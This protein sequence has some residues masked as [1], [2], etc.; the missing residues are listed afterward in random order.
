MNT[1]TETSAVCINIDE[2]INHDD[3]YLRLMRQSITASLYPE[4]AWRIL[5]SEGRKGIIGRIK[6]FMIKQLAKKNLLLVK[7]IPYDANRR[8]FGLDWPMF[9]YSMVGHRRLENIE[10][11]IR[12]VVA[13]NI[14]GDIVEC[15]VWRGGAS[16][17]AKAVLNVLDA[18]NRTLWLADSFE[19]MPVQNEADRV[20]P[21][22]D[23]CSFLAVSLDEVQENFTRFG[24]LDDKVKF[25]KGW[26]SDTL[27][28]APIK[29]IAVLRLDGD[30]YSS[31]MDTLNAL[32]NRVTNGGYIIIDDYGDFESCR[33]AVTEFCG[34]HGIAPII[35]PIDSNGVFWRKV[36]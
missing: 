32:F 14:D 30:Y 11:C 6:Y 20:D 7:K 2:I 3:P 10:K 35:I 25:I 33:R 29:R 9:G 36:E 1:N 15:G 27:P 24:L 18:D 34:N 13:E 28:V 12:S 19:G 23:D 26:F 22:L 5:R 31:T 16:L 8:E 17:Y 21:A 4:S